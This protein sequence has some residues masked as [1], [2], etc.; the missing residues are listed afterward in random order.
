MTIV[1]TEKNGRKTSTGKR[2]AMAPDIYVRVRGSSLFAS[3]MAKASIR[4]KAGEYQYLTWRDGRSVRTFYLGRKRK[5]AQPDPAG[6][7]LD[8]RRRRAAAGPV[9]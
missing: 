5:L 1:K 8:R 7:R 2:R 3:T 9:L 4:V 6:R